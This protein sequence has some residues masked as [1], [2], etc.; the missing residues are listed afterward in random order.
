VLI[1]LYILLQTPLIRNSIK[2]VIKW[3]VLWNQFTIS[4]RENTKHQGRKGVTSQNTLPIAFQREALLDLLQ[5][6][7][8]KEMSR[9]T[10]ILRK[11]AI[12]SSRT[13]LRLEALREQVWRSPTRSERSKPVTRCSRMRR[14]SLDRRRKNRPCQ[15]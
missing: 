5:Q 7:K 4:F 8:Y 11:T 12:A 9:V 1:L 3:T 14:S 10:T 15:R 13:V 2:S 6:A